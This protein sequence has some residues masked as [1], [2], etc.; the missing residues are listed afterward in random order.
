MCKTTLDARQ[1][2]RIVVDAVNK[3]QGQEKGSSNIMYDYGF[4][5]LF[6]RYG[7]II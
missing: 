5:S 1:W 6:L 4:K 7:G 2:K 3:N